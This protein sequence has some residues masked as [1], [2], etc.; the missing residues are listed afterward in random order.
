MIR[1]GSEHALSA[2]AAAVADKRKRES[3]RAKSKN[4]IGKRATPLKDARAAYANKLHAHFSGK[5][6]K[7][8]TAK[9]VTLTKRFAAMTDAD[10]GRGDLREKIGEL[11][12]KS[13]FYS[14]P[15][16]EQ[17]DELAFFLDEETRR[18]ADANR[19]LV[20]AIANL[21]SA[22]ATAVART[23]Y[24]DLRVTLEQKLKEL[25]GELSPHEDL[26]FLKR[27]VEGFLHVFRVLGISE[28]S[29]TPTREAKKPV[30]ALSRVALSA[31]TELGTISHAEFA[32][33]HNRALP[34]PKKG[35][36]PD[37]RR[38]TPKQIEDAIRYQKNRRKTK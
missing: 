22:Y 17:T 29:T 4:S 36:R 9:L 25:R 1:V 37:P 35:E 16:L 23:R 2:G 18:V 6:I 13:G 10:P 15:P 8:T 26:F 5:K 33:H 12:L 38:V 31:K 32:D 20:T 19:D 30:S 34:K 11:R 27:S 21:E 28:K 3:K 24:V 7:A 14:A